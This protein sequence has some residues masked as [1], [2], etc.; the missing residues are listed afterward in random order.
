MREMTWKLLTKYSEE[1]LGIHPG[2]GRRL[3]H[4]GVF[5][6]YRLTPGGPFYVKI[7]EADAIM[8]DGRL[9][10]KTASIGPVPVKSRRA[11]ATA[12]ARARWAKT[13][14]EPAV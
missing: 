4:Q 9:R 6:V 5:P 3:A 12:A 13:E 10:P 14:G 1:D 8:K 11:I 2:S 7:E